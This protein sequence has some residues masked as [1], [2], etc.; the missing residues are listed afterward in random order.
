MAKSPKFHI[1]AERRRFLADA[2]STGGRVLFSGERCVCDGDSTLD[3]DGG[4]ALCKIGLIGP[5]EATDES[6]QRLP[7]P[8]GGADAYVYTVTD[9]GRGSLG[10]LGVK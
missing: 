10:A 5:V 4:A 8:K 7:T 6:T 1:P 3:Y 9:A 2:A